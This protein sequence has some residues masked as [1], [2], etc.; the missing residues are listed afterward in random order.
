MAQRFFWQAQH[1]DNNLF[2]A[3]LG[4]VEMLFQ[5]GFGHKHLTW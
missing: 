3:I 5:F 4:S 2:G 1:C